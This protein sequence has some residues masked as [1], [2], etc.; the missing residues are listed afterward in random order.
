MKNNPSEWKFRDGKT[1]KSFRSVERDDFLAIPA[2]HALFLL[3]GDIPVVIKQG[4]SYLCSANIFS[5]TKQKHPKTSDMKTV[6]DKL[7]GMDTTL[8][9]MMGE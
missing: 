9:K 5:Q 1:W 4:N 8:R 2:A 3:D 7:R 6:I